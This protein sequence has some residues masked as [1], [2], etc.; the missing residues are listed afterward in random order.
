MEPAKFN[1]VSL[2]S[3][4][5]PKTSTAN[6]NPFA[7]RF[8]S[9]K[10][11]VSND[12]YLDIQRQLRRIDISPLIKNLYFL[13]SSQL[14][15]YQDFLQ[16]CSRGIHQIL[17]DH[18]QGYYPTEKL[19]KIG[20]GGDCCIVSTAPFDGNRNILLQRIPEHLRAAGF[21]G[22]FYYRVGGFPNPTGKE[23]QYVG[24]PYSFKIFLM[25]EAQKLGFN[26]VLWI[27][28]A[29]Y[30]LR[31]PAPLFEWIDRVGIYYNYGNNEVSKFFI[32]PQTRSLLS[33][34]AHADISQKIFSIVFGLKMDTPSTQLLIE[35]YYKCAEL[36]TP[37]L[38][39]FPEEFVLSAILTKIKNPEWIP[40][41]KHFKWLSITADDDTPEK[42]QKAKH[43][44]FFFYL[45]KH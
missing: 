44:G 22:Y 19:E 33:E 10:K 7:I 3:L 13:S 31:D 21:N 17:I 30:P 41:D 16:R 2:A 26:K 18:E 45:Q 11:E 28:A 40:A 34:L 1:F 23:I 27:D 8:S 9:T 42:I 35:E 15:S 38:S 25:V 39:C 43:D 36:G 37:F 20:E 12:D 5:I 4:G 14:S 29:C 24:V 6:K 32:L